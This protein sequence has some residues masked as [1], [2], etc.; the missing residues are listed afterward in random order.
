MGKSEFNQK[1]QNKTL[2]LFRVR[3]QDSEVFP[4]NAQHQ[5]GTERGHVSRLSHELVKVKSAYKPSGP[6]DWSLSPVS[7]A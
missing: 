4:H 5:P 2:L 7:E 1:T 3:I 6:S